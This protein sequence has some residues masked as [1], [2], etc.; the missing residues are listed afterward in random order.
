MLIKTFTSR[1]LG[2]NTY[3]IACESSREAAV[4]DPAGKAEPIM[5][6]IR[7]RDLHVKYIFNTHGHV[8][9]IWRNKEIKE[10]TGA[11]IHVHEKE[12]AALDKPRWW[13]PLFKLRTRISPPADVLIRDGDRFPLGIL[14]VEVIHTPGHSPGSVCLRVKKRIF[15]GDTLMA[16]TID[17]KADELHTLL[18]SLRDRLMVLS[19]DIRVYPGHGPDTTIQRERLHNFFLRANEETVERILLPRRKRRSA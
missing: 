12:A 9:H 11:P 17:P 7:E 13:L 19:D 5:Q 2:V 8:D 14:N 1:F 10:A 4:I 3:V 6:L 16:G 18:T 15:S